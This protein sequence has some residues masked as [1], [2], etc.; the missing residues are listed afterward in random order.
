[1]ADETG[2]PGN[3]PWRAADALREIAEARRGA[4]ASAW[5]SP[6]PRAVQALMMG[7][8]LAVCASPATAWTPYLIMALPV[9]GLSLSRRMT[10]GRVQLNGFWMRGHARVR[11]GAAAVLLAVMVSALFGKV[12][13]QWPP[14]TPVVGGIAVAALFYGVSRWFDLRLW[15][16]WGRR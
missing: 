11:A 5:P 14:W 1:M 9:L 4:A 13:W 2:F 6:W 8:A 3:D 10:G 16:D 7:A 15:R 12:L